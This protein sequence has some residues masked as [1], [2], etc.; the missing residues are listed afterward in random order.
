MKLRINRS[1][2]RKAVVPAVALLIMGILFG[3]AR[4]S[5]MPHYED[6]GGPLA[7]KFSF[8]EMP[9]KLPPGLNRDRKIRTVRKEYANLQAWISAIGSSV[10]MTDLTGSGLAQDLCLVDPRSD[11]V[12][13][14]PTPDSDTSRYE[15]FVLDPKPLLTDESTVPSGCI[16]GDF[17]GDGRM[18]LLVTYYGRTPILYLQ[19]SDAKKLDAGAF[20]PVDMVPNPNTGD[21]LY[22][23]RRWITATAVVSDFDGKGK[24]DI[25]IGNYF[26][27]MD[28]LAPEGRRSLSMPDGFAT[29]KNGGESKIFTLDT[30]AS[31]HDPDVR[32]SEVSD[33]FPIGMNTGWTLAAAAIDLKGDQLPDLYVANDFGPD[34]LF[35]NKS[36]PGHI[37]F[38]YAVGHRDPQTPKSS[39][40]GQD[41]FKGMAAEW[42]DLC[43]NGK[44]DLFVSNIAVTWGLMEGHFAFCN[45]AKDG[46]DAARRLDAGDAP[47]V[48]RAADMGV[49]FD[50]WGWDAK[51]GDFNNSGHNE[52]VQANGMIKGKVNRWPQIQEIGTMNDDLVKYPYAWPIIGPDAD[53]A[54]SDPVAFYAPDGNGKFVNLTHALGMDTP[55]PSRGIA[56]GDTS[57]NGALSIAVAR[58]WGDPSY[59]HNNRAADAGQFLGLK[60]FKPTYPGTDVTTSISGKPILGVPA[61]D[62]QVEV[63]TP[64]GRLHI[65]H[66]DGGSGHTGK[67]ALEV[68]IGLGQIDPNTPLDVLLRWRDANGGSHEQTIKLAPGWHNVK[69]T[70]DAQEVKG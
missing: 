41:S 26:P 55:V 1:L 9:I 59:Y 5:I 19:R 49:A 68:H 2:L 39:V 7:S 16:P 35:V 33:A 37:K 14:T 36:T 6:A 23:G 34:H 25:F 61:V 57:G 20:R 53:L 50:T 64:D 29:A 62:T 32:Y 54:G 13:I 15:P 46:A 47:F 56:V 63:R 4:G 45:T 24:P 51:L 10:A 11:S 22:H 21:G 44:P 30:Y 65:G 8:T 43:G 31:G 70:A 52:L 66:L 42:G 38:D 40:M 48:N 17:N 67:R 58:Q 18:G 69:L 27:E 28:V 3:P 60:L 12:I